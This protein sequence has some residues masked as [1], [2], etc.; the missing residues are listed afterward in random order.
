MN[1]RSHLHDFEVRSLNRL[2]RIE[3]I[4]VPSRIWRAGDIPVASVVR[5]DH[6]VLFQSAKD[7]LSFWRERGY[8]EAGFQPNAHSHWWKIGA[9]VRARP[10]TG[11]RDIRFASMRNCKPQG[12]ID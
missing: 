6:P 1:D 4:V 8:I 7:D 11:R 9:R 2:Q 5:D 10:V 12:M 3:L